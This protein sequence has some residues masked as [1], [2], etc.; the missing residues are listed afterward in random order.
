MLEEGEFSFCEIAKRFGRNISTVHDFFSSC[1]KKFRRFRKII[2][3]AATRHYWEWKRPCLACSC[4]PSYWWTEEIRAAVC[5]TV[6]QQTFTNWLLHGQLQTP[7][8]SNCYADI[9]E[10]Y[11]RGVL[12]HTNFHSHTDVVSQYHLQSVGIL[13]WPVR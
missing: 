12:Q 1:Q 9:H 7:W 5:S 2:F 10:Q 6:T 11:S 4:D 3:Q 13:L 8:C